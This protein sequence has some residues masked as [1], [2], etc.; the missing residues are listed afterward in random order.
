VQLRWHRRVARTGSPSS[1]PDELTGLSG[2]PLTYCCDQRRLART[3]RFRLLNASN[4]RAYDVGFED[5]RSFQLIGTDG[6]LLERPHTTERVQLS[7]GERAE[8]LVPFAPGER[9]ILRSF[10]PELGLNWFQDRFAGGDDTFDLLQVR[11]ARELHSGSAPVALLTDLAGPV[12]ADAVKTRVIELNGSSRINGRR[13]D[14]GRV[15]FEVIVGTTE[16]W[17]LRNSSD[18]V[19]NF[20]VHDVQFRILEYGGRPPPPHLG[21]RKDTLLLPPGASARVLAEFSDYADGSTPYMSTVTS[22]PTRTTA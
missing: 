22:S 14:M 19:H 5:E 15:D 12:E 7:P 21:G 6:G 1:A 17:E 16:V 11:S 18:N 20:H 9:V 3:V 10:P 2:L 8:V 4:A 13:V